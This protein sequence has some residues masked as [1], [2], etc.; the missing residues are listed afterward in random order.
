MRRMLVVWS[1]VSIIAFTTHGQRVGIGTTSPT[2]D[3]HVVGQIRFES[4]ASPNKALL[5]VNNIG[6]VDTIELNGD[7]SKVLLGDGTWGTI[8]GG[9]NW[10]SQ[11][12]VTSFPL[13]GDG[14][15]SSPISLIN[16]GSAGDLLIWNG[17]QWTV[18]QPGPASGIA[19]IC[20]SPTNNYILKW[21]GTDLCNSQIFDDGT[22][23]GIGVTAP[24]AKL[25]VGGNLQIDGDFRPG[26]NP[27]TAGYILVSQGAGAPPTWQS[28]TTAVP[29]YGTNVQSAKLTTVAIHTNPGTWQ[30]ILTITFTPKHST[31][32]VFASFTARLTDPSGLAQ[33]G[34]ALVKARILVNGVEVAKATSIITD[35]GY[36]YNASTYWVVTGGEIA[37]AGVPVTVTPGSSTTIKLQ[38]DIVHAWAS[39]SWQVRIDP[40]NTNTGDHAVLTVFD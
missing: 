5:I 40:T 22:N 23:V 36:D 39:G 17:S 10:G 33:M 31:V 6:V 30:D 12:A 1:A 20:N 38:W 7:P 34:Q 11:T 19:S 28:P 8:S 15:P 16:G 32:F 9:D 21:T 24:S 29:V 37:F 27:G 13:V 26:G 3:F 25:H 2:H 14:T 35:Q 4:L 18:G